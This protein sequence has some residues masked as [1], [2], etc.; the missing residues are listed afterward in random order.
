MSRGGR[1]ERP[2]GGS[3]PSLC[4]VATLLSSFVPADAGGR[5]Q[6]PPAGPALGR[7]PGPA[8]RPVL[9]RPQLLRFTSEILNYG[10]GPFEVRGDRPTTGRGFDLDQILSPDRRH[11]PAASRRTPVSRTPGTGT[12]TTTSGG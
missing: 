4:L 5:R 10:A 3:A 11:D 9:E 12:T 7:D 6:R 2:P 8:H 1:R